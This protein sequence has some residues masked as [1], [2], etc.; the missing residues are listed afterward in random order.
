M[1]R[2]KID[3]LEWHSSYHEPDSPL[4]RRLALVQAH[5]RNALPEHLDSPF[6]IVSL[7]AG[8]GLDVLEV[9]AAYPHAQRVRARLVELDERNVAAA[10]KLANAAGLSQVEIVQGDAGRLAAYEGAVPADIVLVCG[11]FGNIGE[12][13]IFHT[14]ARLPQLCQQGATVLWT[15]HRRAPDLT[16]AIRASFEAH[17]LPEVA[18]VAPEE[19]FFSVGANRYA[20]EPLPLQPE[21]RLFPEFT[22]LG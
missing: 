3:W 16:P 8:Q 22:F 9:L 17:H 7:C 20:G 2:E 15:R 21:E 1:T 5:L 6:Q 14:I 19:V 18:F 4:R 13:E 11:V 10:R 12:R